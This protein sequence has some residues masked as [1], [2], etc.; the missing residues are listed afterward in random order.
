MNRAGKALLLDLTSQGHRQRSQTNYQAAP[1]GDRHPER[2]EGKVLEGT[3]R[4]GKGPG[5]QEHG[6]WHQQR[7]RKAGA[8]APCGW[9]LFPPPFFRQRVL[10]SPCQREGG[11]GHSQQMTSADDTASLT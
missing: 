1:G 11:A 7:K 3:Q 2:H 5:S 6:A 9:D 10:P 4:Q 8:V